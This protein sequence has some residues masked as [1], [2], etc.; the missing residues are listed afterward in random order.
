MGMSEST[1]KI[2]GWS[3]A[4][5]IAYAVCLFANPWGGAFRRGYGFCARWP[6]FWLLIGLVAA[7]QVWWQ[8][9]GTLPSA[10][11]PP[12]LALGDLWPHWS[13]ALLDA[14]NSLVS[15]LWLPVPAEPVSVLLAPLVLLNVAQMGK[16][17]WAGCQA[18]FGSLGK[19]LGV[20]LILSAI[21]RIAWFGLSVS[22]HF[23]LTSPSIIYLNHAG[24]LWS[25]ATVAFALAWLLRFSETS[26]RKPEEIL[27]I[28]WPSSAAGRIPRLWPAILAV[29]A[30]HFTPAS[31][32]ANT[33][34]QIAC[35]LTVAASGFYPLLLLHWKDL[36]GWRKL[37]LIGLHRLKSYS[38]RLLWWLVVAFTH[39][40]AFHLLRRSII[41][42]LPLNNA[43]TLLAHS[44]LAL[45]HAAA[46]T[47]MLA[48]WVSLQP[49]FSEWHVDAGMEPLVEKKI[50][51]DIWK[52]LRSAAKRKR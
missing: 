32:Q 21:C 9:R 6:R 50:K 36:W 4:G 52:Q 51:S 12:A 8:A 23:P 16:A 17:L 46:Q 31:L 22:G 38:G 20:L 11:F 28:N 27:L 1:W 18:A 7:Q 48:S 29:V 3:A 42:P 5:I 47:W 34:L 19:A 39:F 25:G 45:A 30:L 13:Q 2:L 49:P 43:W 26:L 24:V 35:F 15:T 44:L 41:E 40:A 33:G 37:G 14:G 10:V